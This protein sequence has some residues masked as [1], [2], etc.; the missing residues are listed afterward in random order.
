MGISLRFTQISHSGFGKNGVALKK[1][2]LM[3]ADPVVQCNGVEVPVTYSKRHLL[4]LLAL[5]SGKTVSKTA[6]A[7]LNET[8]EEYAASKIRYLREELK[9]LKCDDLIQ[10]VDSRGYRINLTGWE[11]DA[12]QFKQTILAVGGNIKEG[13]APEDARAAIQK[14]DAVLKLWSANPADGLPNNNE[15][16]AEFERLYNRGQNHLLMARLLSGD[17]DIMRE[18]VITLESRT[19]TEPDESDWILLLRA[20]ATLG[21]VHHTQRTWTRI[22]E[23]YGERSISTKLRHTA[24]AAMKLE[25]SVLFASVQSDVGGLTASLPAAQAPDGEASLIN[26]VKTLGIATSSQLKLEGSQMTPIQCIER[27]RRRLYFAGVLASKWVIEPSVRSAFDE[28]LTRLDKKGGD[29]RF[30][31]I[32][33]FSK[34]YKRLHSI[35]KGN[36]SAESI[37]HLKKLLAAHRSFSVRVYDSLPAFRIVIIDDDVVTFSPY[38][39]PIEVYKRTDRGWNAP[40]VVLDPLAPYPLAEAFQLLFLETWATATP[41]AKLK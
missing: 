37:P 38:R 5:N 18:A 32:N 41:I 24:T 27:T 39:L 19:Q 3:C 16:I 8:G 11:V 2:S 25:S 14:L 23:S 40:H 29:V 9:P 28:L 7:E 10:T 36:V 30:L 35:R 13:V 22:Q 15:L 12:L 21:N 33:P 26:L 20:Y 6:I 34:S 4:R 1:I 17:A 31:V